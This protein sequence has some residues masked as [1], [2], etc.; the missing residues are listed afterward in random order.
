[1]IRNIK[2]KNNNIITI[3]IIIK[4]P[5]NVAS[6]EHMVMIPKHCNEMLRIVLQV[7]LCCSFS[8]KR[9]ACSRIASALSKLLN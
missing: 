2:K 4:H 8:P 9:R 6:V 5:W 3:I 1:M 7:T